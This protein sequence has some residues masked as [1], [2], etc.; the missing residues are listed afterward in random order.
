VRLIRVLRLIGGTGMPPGHHEARIHH[1]NRSGPSVSAACV[2]P[3]T[4]V[5][6]GEFELPDQRSARAR[7]GVP[8]GDVPRMSR[9]RSLIRDRDGKFPALFD[10][11]LTDAGI[12]VALGKFTRI[13][14][15][16]DLTFCNG[17]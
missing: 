17:L 9:A 12:K 10:D 14:S 6:S 5:V 1:H 16:M 7:A 2:V 4:S 8:G 3:V 15:D 13:Y 11:V